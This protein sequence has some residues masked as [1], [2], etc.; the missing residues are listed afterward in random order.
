MRCHR[1]VKPFP[2]SSNNWTLNLYI[3]KINDT[4]YFPMATICSESLAS[5]SRGVRTY[6]WYVLLFHLP[7]ILICT[8]D[9][10]TSLAV[11]AA[12]IRKLCVLYHLSSIP[13]RWRVEVTKEANSCRVKYKSSANTNKGPGLAP[14]IT[15]YGMIAQ[16][17]QM[18][19]PLFPKYRSTPCLNGSVFDCLWWLVS[20]LDC[21][22][23]PRQCP[24]ATSICPNH[25]P[26][27]REQ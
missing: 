21:S 1:K 22:C 19:F 18:S 9:M 6:S 27:E 17:G 23:H 2:P 26:P 4:A 3:R 20:L 14:L 15:R 25:M 8:S 11:V 12:P 10:P 5:W 13:V 24:A 7:S 16:T